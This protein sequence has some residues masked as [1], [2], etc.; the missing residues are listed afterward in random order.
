MMATVR[1]TEGEA[2]NRGKLCLPDPFN[3]EGTV[4]V[5]DMLFPR[6]REVF[7]F[8]DPVTR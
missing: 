5:F 6:V 7:A 4:M 2:Q 1:A 3:D 8:F